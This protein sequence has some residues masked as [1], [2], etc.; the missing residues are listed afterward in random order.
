MS[1]GAHRARAEREDQQTPLA[2]AGDHRWRIRCVGSE[3]ENENIRLCRGEID[4]DALAAGK[5]FGDQ[6]RVGVIIGETFHVSF[7]SVQTRGCED[8]DLA[9]RAARHSPVAQGALDE[10]ARAGEQRA[11]RCAEALR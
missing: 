8:A 7:Q 5:P 2:G 10:R 9:H 3:V 4:D 11:A 1:H 6:P